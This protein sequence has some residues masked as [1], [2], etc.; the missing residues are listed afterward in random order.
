MNK[1]I[2]GALAAI[3]TLGAIPSA[4]GYSLIGQRILVGQTKQQIAHC[5]GGQLIDKQ[6]I[7]GGSIWTY[8][9][10]GRRTSLHVWQHSKPYDP[11]TDSKS[12]SIYANAPASLLYKID[13]D[14]RFVF[15]GNRVRRVEY[16]SNGGAWAHKLVCGVVTDYCLPY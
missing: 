4:M 11:T 7:R 10:S 6:K 3:V 16:Y 12:G 15:K 5:A 13:C 14:V 8:R 1:L 9:S 2:L